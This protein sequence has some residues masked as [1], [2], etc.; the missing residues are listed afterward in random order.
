MSAEQ[1]PGLHSRSQTRSH[2][3]VAG[4]MLVLACAMFGFGYLMVPLYNIICDI[5]GLN[6]KTGRVSIASV[7]PADAVV[8]DREIIVEFVASINQG[9]SW[10]F[11][12]MVKTMKVVPG[13]LYNA[14]Y[15]AE[16]LS[17][18]A[19][20]A[21]ATPSVTPFA[22][23]KYFNKTECFCFT[24]QAFEPKG[25]KDMPL[26]FIID[27]DLPVNIDRVTLSYTFFRSPEQT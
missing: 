1:S 6:G 26:T 16:N 11:K 10:V 23:A 17:N 12:P 20:V 13:K 24:R 2:G 8:D 5:T 9:G 21:Q 25:S 15:Y 14:S 22:A 19:V 4:K 3:W 27:E 7:A 18:N